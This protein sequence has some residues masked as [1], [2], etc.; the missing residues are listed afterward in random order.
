MVYQRAHVEDNSAST[1]SDRKKTKEHAN[2]INVTQRL[3]E[4]HR[5]RT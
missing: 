1:L 4:H 3:N 2:P 5:K